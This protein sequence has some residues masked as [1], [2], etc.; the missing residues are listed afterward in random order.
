[1]KN[2]LERYCIDHSRSE[3][4]LQKKIRE[5]TFENETYPQM[6]SGPIVGNFLGSLIKLM[7]AKQVLEVGMFTGYSAASMVQFLPEDGKIHT[8]EHMDEH[9]QTADNFFKNSKFK[10]M[11][12]IHGGLAIDTLEQ[13][14]V[15]SFDFVF[16]DA[17]KINYLNYY[18]RCMY[19]LKTNGIIV[20]DNMLWSGE[21]MDPK[22]ED[23][24]I[25]RE[26]GDYIQNDDRVINMLFPIRDGLMVCMKK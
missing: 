7:C 23:S 24:R 8:C 15:N 12:K 25:L 19:L 6:I 17:D 14:K 9:I 20:L 1:M 2:K 18:Q 21:V 16:I 22:N 4:S 26:T 13:F 3:S 11:I 5:Y 10:D